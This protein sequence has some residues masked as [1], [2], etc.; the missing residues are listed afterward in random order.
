MSAVRFKYNPAHCWLVAHNA[1]REVDTLVPDPADGVGPF[2]PTAEE[3]ALAHKAD[4]PFDGFSVDELAGRFAS[5]RRNLECLCVAKYWLESHAASRA[6]E[7]GPLLPRDCVEKGEVLAHELFKHLKHEHRVQAAEDRLAA[8]DVLDRAWSAL[9]YRLDVARPLRAI[10]LALEMPSAAQ[11][12]D[13]FEA[14][15]G[16]AR[17]AG[18]TFG[19]EAA[20]ATEQERIF[21]RHMLLQAAGSRG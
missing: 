9:L 18:E 14:R 2:G 21:A 1:S 11:T 8:P 4:E 19:D 7:G 6:V 5:D 10:A 20:C 12:A 3:R 16:R 13:A 15:C 17:A